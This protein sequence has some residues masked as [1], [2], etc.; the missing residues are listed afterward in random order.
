MRNRGC[1]CGYFPLW[2]MVVLAALGPGRAGAV[3]NANLLGVIT[4]VLT[5]PTGQL[6]LR[7]SNQP[8]SHPGCNPAF[9]VVDE[10][11]P[12]AAM[13]RLYARAL[14]ALHSGEV[15]NIGF[16][17]QGDCANGYIRVHRIG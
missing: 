8:T 12:D 11:T 14:S 7:L 4:D 9:F 6:Y 10:T 13:A 15:I 1:H 3:Y 16:D 5:Y 17:G 2:V